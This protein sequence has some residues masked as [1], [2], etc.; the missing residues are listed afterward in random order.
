L[1]PDEKLVLLAA[2]YLNSTDNWKYLYCM[3]CRYKIYN[4]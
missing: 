4:D 3:F 1:S 2:D